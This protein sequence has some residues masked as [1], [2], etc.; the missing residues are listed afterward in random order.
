MLTLCSHQL[1]ELQQWHG[2]LPSYL[3]EESNPEY[4][5]GMGFAMWLLEDTT[6]KDIP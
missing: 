4:F 6:K 3:S 2:A 5:G 1:S